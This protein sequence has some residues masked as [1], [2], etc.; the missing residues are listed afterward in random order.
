VIAIL[1]VAVGVTWTGL[2][3]WHQPPYGD[4]VRYQY[5]T[6]TLTV[7]QYH[8][9]F[10]PLI[11]HLVNPWKGNLGQLQLLQLG[12]LALCLAYFVYALRAADFAG[13]ANERRGVVGAFVSLLLLLL[14][15]PLLAHFSLSLMQDSLALSGCLVF[16]AALAKLTCDGARRWAAAALLFAGFVL[17]AG[18]RIEKSWALLATALATLPAWFLIARGFPSANPPRLRASAGVVLAAVLLGF[19]AAQSIQASMYREPPPTAAFRFSHWPK[20]TTVLHQRIV[21][22]NLTS[23]YEELSPESRAVLTRRDAQS[24]DRRIHH[25]WSV[26]DRVT[27]GDP[28]ARGRLTRDLASTAF[29]NRWAAITADVASDTAE[30]VFAPLSFYAR[31]IEWSMGGTDRLAWEL[32]FEATP[33]LGADS[34][35]NRILRYQ[36]SPKTQL[37]LPIRKSPLRRTP[38]L[39]PEAFTTHA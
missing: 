30:N 13:G 12:V 22:P 16:S 27:R 35:L 23:V 24:Y 8:G 21:F 15:D 1:Y 36:A 37:E 28:E 20:L 4:S 17:A 5:F 34:R 10:Y 38:L 31:L 18:V 29:R 14:L 25:T 19:A 26:T 3:L 9:G 6:E 32:R 39:I 11:L 33:P 7:D 2:N